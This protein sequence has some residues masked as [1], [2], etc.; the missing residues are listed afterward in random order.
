MGFA[1]PEKGRLMMARTFYLP[2]AVATLLACLVTLSSAGEAGASFP[3]RSGQIAFQKYDGA[4][5][6]EIYAVSPDGSGLRQ[7]TDS[8]RQDYEAAWSA[9][10]TKIVISRFLTEDTELFVG[11]LET[12]RQTRITN[13]GVPDNY[14]VFSPD[15]S[16][17]AF[18]SNRD[19][20]NSANDDIYVMNVTGG[21]MKRLTTDPAIDAE[22]NWSPDG[23]KIAFRR[24]GG[25][26]IW[27][28]NADGSGQVNLTPNSASI[29]ERDPSWSPDGAKIAFGVY[30]V[31]S[32][33]IFTMDAD[34]SNKTNVTATPRVTEAQPT[35]SPGGGRI[36]YVV[37]DENG[38]DVWTMKTDGTDRRNITN[39]PNESEYY[40]DWGPKPVTAG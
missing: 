36:G 1:L 16:K 27:V 2:V 3:G 23:T 22:P 29:T 39:T 37:N 8:P 20:L 19:P 31:S 11:D 5:D 12:G 7:L 38:N 32:I 33:D 40:P 15:G 24:G 34:G 17:V 30:G 18:Q 14:A 4:H 26:D 35:W 25:G 6:S 9:S 10:G 28:M 21:G 13:N